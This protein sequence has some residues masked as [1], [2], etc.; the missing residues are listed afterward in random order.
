MQN[1]PVCSPRDQGIP[2]LEQVS[3]HPVVSQV[4]QPG[5]SALVCGVP[6]AGEGGGA[7]TGTEVGRASRVC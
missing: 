4:L 7:P 5:A 6:C 2:E 3:T 1:L